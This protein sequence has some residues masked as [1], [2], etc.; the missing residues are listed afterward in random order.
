MRGTPLDA[1][2]PYAEMSGQLGFVAPMAAARAEV[3]WLKGRHDEVAG[4][5]EGALELAIDR[6]S[7]WEMG[8]LRILAQ[9]CGHSRGAPGGRGGALR[10]AALR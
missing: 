5:T 10:R 7:P 4:M 3:A 9:V 1:A 8:E 2:F 6:R